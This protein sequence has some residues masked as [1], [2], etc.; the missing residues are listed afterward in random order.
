MGRELCTQHNGKGG[1]CIRPALALQVGELDLC[2]LVVGQCK[3]L[4]V[5]GQLQQCRSTTLQ[6]HQPR[7][8]WCGWHLAASHKCVLALCCP[9]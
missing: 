9:P 7:K 2:C 6:C 3:T 4:R 5:R 8:C 1:V